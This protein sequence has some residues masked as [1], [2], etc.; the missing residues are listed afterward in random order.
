MNR[1]SIKPVLAAASL[2]VVALVAFYSLAVHM[3]LSLGK[4]PTSIGNAG[5]S[6]AL[7]VH[8]E[9]QFLIIELLA[10]ISLF[11]WPAAVGICVFT[12]RARRFLPHLIF[13][14]G[15]VL[16]CVALMYCA[17]APFLN[18]WKD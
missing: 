5:F 6:R 2:P 14:A 11:L 10:V 16:L 12:L 17:P 7:T 8:D 3:Y 9:V 1:L 15:A 4:W 13:Y 18:W